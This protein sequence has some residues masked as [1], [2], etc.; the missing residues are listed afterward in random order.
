MF[1]LCGVALIG[2]NS[3]SATNSSVNATNVP[4]TVTAVNP[5]NNAVNVTLNKVIN[6][7]FS[8]PIK[9]GNYWIEL[10]SSNGTV[11]PIKKSIKT[12]H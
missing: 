3:T 1:L 10:Q 5:S 11:I 9:A 12:T 6:V 2:L 4:L 8:E 7:T